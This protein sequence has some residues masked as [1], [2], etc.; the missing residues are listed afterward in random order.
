M[1]PTSRGHQIPAPITGNPKGGVRSMPLRN[2]WGGCPY[3][4]HPRTAFDT[5][6]G[7]PSQPSGLSRPRPRPER[8]ASSTTPKSRVRSTDGCGLWEPICR[9]AACECVSC[10][11]LDAF[12]FD[13][14]RLRCTSEN[15]TLPQGAHLTPKR[16][17]FGRGGGLHHQVDDQLRAAPNM[18]PA[19]RGYNAGYLGLTSTAPAPRGNPCTSVVFFKTLSPSCDSLATRRGGPPQGHESGRGYCGM[20]NFIP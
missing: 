12:L 4:P 1:A 3:R 19:S 7:P 13:H 6:L 5:L 17:A 14:L 2:P 15:L 16:V 20:T 10:G 8:A 9:R 18:I 11:K